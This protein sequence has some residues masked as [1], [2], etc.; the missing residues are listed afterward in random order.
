MSNPILSIIVPT[1][2]RAK[3]AIPCIRSLINIPSQELEIVVHDNSET[4][5]LDNYVNTEIKDSRLIYR[6]TKERLDVVANFSKAIEY[7]HGE[8]IAF[9]GDDDGVNPEI[10]DAALWAKKN[11]IDA[12]VTTRPAQY[13]WPDK[14]ERI[15]ALKQAGELTIKRFTSRIKSAYPEDAMKKC[16]KL[17]GSNIVSLPK[18]YYG[19]AKL[20]CMEKVKKVAGT[21]FPGPSPDLAGAM[22]IANYVKRMRIIDYPLFLPGASAVGAAGWVARGKHQGQ[23]EDYP[24]L[25]K[26]YI[27]IWSKIVPKYFSGST[28]WGEDVVQALVAVGRNDILREFN[29]PLLHAKCAV[30]N[31]AYLIVTLRNFYPALKEIEKGYLIGTLKFIY[32]YIYLWAVRGKY[33]ALNLIHISLN[34][35]IFTVKNLIDID[36][37]T[38]AMQ[39]YLN[40]NSKRFDKFL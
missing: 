26:K 22:A 38:K 7:A 17:A 18:I 33:L 3:Y 32:Y 6:H 10:V 40:E 4:N 23:L 9:I 14:M 21:C 28:I 37:A 2:N 1:R 36:E 27:R 15:Y 20:E 25:P 34:D 16:A 13:K 39:K 24:H 11:R 35:G 12:L 8:Y 5:E 31:P 30:F 19:L 29:V